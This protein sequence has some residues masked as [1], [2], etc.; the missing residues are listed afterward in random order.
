MKINDRS[1]ALAILKRVLFDKVNLTLAMENKELT[2]FSRALCFGLC[3]YYFSLEAIALKLLDKKS[4]DEEIWL[5]ILLGLYQLIYLSKPAA[6]TVKETVDLIPAKKQWARGF[7]N[8]VLRRFCRESQP[9]LP[10]SLVNHPAWLVNQLKRDWA[11][12]WQ[13][14]LAANDEHPPFTLRV[15]QQKISTKAY[16]DQLAKAGIQARPLLHAKDGLVLEKAVDLLQ[17]PGFTEGWISVQDEAA[18]YAAEL[19]DLK[20]GL[21]VLDACAAPGGKLCH[22]LEKAPALRCVGLDIEQKRLDRIAQNLQ[23]LGLEASLIKGDAT[24]PERWWDGMTFDRILL[25]VPCS[26]LGVIRRHPDIKL[27]RREEDIKTIVLKQAQILAAIWPLVK[28]GGLVLYA[29]CSILK[30]ENADQIA[31]FSASHADCDV[32]PLQK[33]WGIDSGFGLQILPGKSN[34]D[35]FFYSLL[36]KI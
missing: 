20:P 21:R 23:R 27:L 15:N 17:L 8:A 24:E 3:R 29:T 6:V 5:I 28:S 12:E 32:V 13:T 14:L 26:A 4:K 25:D 2:S 30:Q 10:D 35:G 9:S 19:L 34:C 22:M 36:K 16:L 31:A 1:H 11:E 7:V 33:P 18:Q